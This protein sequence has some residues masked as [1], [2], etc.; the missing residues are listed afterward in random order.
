[1][2]HLIKL[3]DIKSNKSR[4]YDAE[5]IDYKFFH[6]LTGKDEKVFELLTGRKTQKTFAKELIK[7]EKPEKEFKK[8]SNK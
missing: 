4:W 8:K 6:E 1:M 3:K 7:S 5:K 2:G